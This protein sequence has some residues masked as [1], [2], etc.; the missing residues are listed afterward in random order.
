MQ[1][2]R[3]GAFDLQ[4]EVGVIAE[5]VRLPLDDL[6]LVVDAFQPPRVERIKAVIADLVAE[7]PGR[8][9]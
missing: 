7:C 3:E 8:R 6:D 9:L 1:S 5:A 2:A 4:D